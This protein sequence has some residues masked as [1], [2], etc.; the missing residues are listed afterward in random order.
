MVRS[1]RGRAITAG[2]DIRSDELFGAIRE[3]Y[4]AV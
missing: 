4:V 2:A 1:F 3:L